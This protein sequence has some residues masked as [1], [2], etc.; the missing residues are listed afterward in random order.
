MQSTTSTSLCD[1]AIFMTVKMVIFR[2]EIV[3]FLIFAQNIEFGYTSEPVLTSTHYLC[4]R[5]KVRKIGM[6]CKPQWV[7]RGCRLHGYVVMMECVTT[8]ASLSQL[9][10]PAV[11]QYERRCPHVL[12]VV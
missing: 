10:S 7:V 8:E 4:F 6:P 1:T 3:F 9:S 11:E 2:W 5:A 12:D